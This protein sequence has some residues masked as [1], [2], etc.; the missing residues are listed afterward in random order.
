[1]QKNYI[2]P[3]LSISV[4]RIA[5]LSLVVLL[6][7]TGCVDMLSV[8]DKSTADEDMSTDMQTTSSSDSEPMGFLHITAPETVPKSEEVANHEQVESQIISEGLRKIGNSTEYRQNLTEKQYNRTRQ[9][10]SKHEYHSSSEP[11]FTSGLFIEYNGKTYNINIV[12][13]GELV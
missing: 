2:Y 5:I 10:L 1:M 13:Y 12:I 7:I 8:P 4:R 11:N 6:A 3:E 9:A